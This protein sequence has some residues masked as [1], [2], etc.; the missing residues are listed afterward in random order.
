MA[1]ILLG[2][3]HSIA[4]VW[5]LASVLLY[6]L[7]FTFQK[8]ILLTKA[9]YQ[10][11]FINGLILST[12]LTLMSWLYTYHSQ[13]IH[14]S[15]HFSNINSMHLCKL[16]ISEVL[17]RKDKYNKYYANVELTIDSLGRAYQAL[18]KILVYAYGD[19]NRKTFERGDELLV[20]GRIEAIKAPIN[21]GDFDYK[22][23]LSVKDIHHSI[24][25]NE[26]SI[27]WI[28]HN[29]WQL[30]DKADN[31]RSACNN[32]IK[33]Y[34]NAKQ[35]YGVA[36]A[37]L[38]GY[39]YDI[40]L[41]VNQVFARTGTLHVLAVSGMHVGLIYGLLLWIC[42]FI[43]STGYK[44]LIRF[45]IILVGIWGYA[46]LSGLGASILRATVMF[47]FMSVAQLTE[48]KTQSF[49]LLAASA[50]FLFLND[51]L[52]LFDPGFQL[53]YSAVA[54]IIFLYPLLRP[55][56]QFN[57]KI[58]TYIAELLSL[59]IAA[60]IFTF[61]FSLYYFGQFPNLFLVANL[62]I[63]PLS[64]ILIF[65]LIALAISPF[66]IINQFLGK[67]LELGLDLNYKFAESI[68]SIPYA[69]SEGLYI[70]SIELILWLFTSSLLVIYLYSKNNKLIVLSMVLICLLTSK[71]LVD[72]WK[73]IHQNQICV[74]TIDYKKVPICMN[75]NEAII[76]TDSFN[77]NTTNF[78]SQ[79]LKK[80]F[81]LH[82][83]QTF[84]FASTEK[85]FVSTNFLLIPG[86]G[87]Q[88]FDKTMTMDKSG[89]NDRHRKKQL[90]N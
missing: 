63:I 39:K 35:N 84:R 33:T 62:V 47:S 18:G 9:K 74:Y 42:G 28:G 31:I 19:S 37:L 71:N 70:D 79:S 50:F 81:S 82:G 67:C 83:I 43:G 24:K 85:L 17:S 41:G 6:V 49:N 58:G 32:K 64:T 76:V 46:M 77:M 78:S 51:P 55:Y 44:K 11:R 26:A 48:R 10:S 23:Y 65:G 61:P 89:Q 68:S 66:D 57:N 5:V 69:V 12:M 75:G 59:T 87:F 1:G 80:Y 34:I 38:L 90:K 73:N 30:L 20:K 2:F 22:F 3:H 40:D 4:P 52:C 27:K 36:E 45:L 29:N 21:E 88:F 13:T 53:S 56:C 72:R 14:R 86:V 15:R 54:G 7:Y 8:S 60:Q 25:I 16:S